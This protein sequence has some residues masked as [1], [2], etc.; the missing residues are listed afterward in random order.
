M[1]RVLLAGQEIGIGERLS[2]LHG[3]HLFAEVE[4][5]QEL[6]LPEGAADAEDVGRAGVHR[7]EC[8]PR[9]EDLVGGADVLERSERGE[10]P[11]LIAFG[12]LT[13]FRESPVEFAAVEI[14][15]VEFL[16]VELTHLVAAVDDG[17]AAL[18]E[19]VGVEHDVRVNGKTQRVVVVVVDGG[20][21]TAKA[22]GGAAE[23]RVL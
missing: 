4:E 8:R 22:G 21:N 20:F 17:N 18:R 6:L 5:C 11:A 7:I 14:A 3:S 10:D 16:I 9:L 2:K 19:H 15:A 13:L 23:T 12:I 1:L